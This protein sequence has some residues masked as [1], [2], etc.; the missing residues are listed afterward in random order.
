MAVGRLNIRFPIADFRYFHFPR[1][2]CRPDGKHRWADTERILPPS[3]DSAISNCE[4]T[5]KT[6]LLVTFLP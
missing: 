2:V 3:I 4:W 6:N 5:L 1:G